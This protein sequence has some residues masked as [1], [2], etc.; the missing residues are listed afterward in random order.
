MEL[1]MDFTDIMEQFSENK[2]RTRIRRAIKIMAF[3]CESSAKRTISKNSVDS[4]RFLNSVWHEL[5]EDGDEMGFTMYDGVDYGIYHE[6]GTI[7]H[8]LPFFYYGDT[9]KPVLADWA[10][11]V[12]GM[13]DEEM[14]AQ[15]GMMVEIKETMPFRK[16]LLNIKDK[17]QGIFDRQFKK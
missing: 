9:S 15:G 3:R 7:R 5:W 4:G 12:L 16:A 17:A 6:F 11:H 8:W 13:T 10:R 2:I 14:L 1:E